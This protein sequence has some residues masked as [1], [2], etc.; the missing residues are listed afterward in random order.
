MSNQTVKKIVILGGG[1]AGW[2]TAAA[3]SKFLGVQYCEIVLVESDEIGTVGVGEAT[4]PPMSIFNKSLGIDENDFLKNTQGTFKLGIEFVNW[5]KIGSRYIHAFGD[6][7]KDMNSMHFYQYWLKMHLAGEAAHFQEYGL[8]AKACNQKKFMRSENRGNSP[9]SNIAY[10]F[11]FDASLYAKYLRNYAEQKGIMR[12]EGKVQ[13]VNLRAEDG[14]IESLVLNNGEVIDG[15]LFIDC[16]G[17]KALLIG[18]ALKVGYEDWTHWLP[19]DRAWAVQ[20]EGTPDLLPYTR[21]TAHEAGWQWRIPLQHR[22]GNGHVFASQYMSEEKA[23]DILLKNLD[24]KPLTEPRLIKFTTGKRKE[25]WHKNCVSVGLASGFLEPLESTSIH[26]VQSAIARI[27][28]LFPSNNFNQADINEFNRQS[29]FEYEKIRDFII[30]HY[31]ANERDDSEFWRYC[32]NMSVPEA[33]SRRIELFKSS[34]RV[35]RQTVEMFSELSWVE[36][37]LGQGITPQSYDRLVDRMPEDEIAQRLESVRQVI[38]RS[39]DYM[40]THADFIAHNCKAEK[41]M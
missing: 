4:V 15:D 39:V 23:R 28:A 2:M 41:M 36:V 19:C 38:S 1:T 33:L 10:A 20:C 37:L 22:L 16:S 25:I 12:I 34:G 14:F 26:L 5:G 7:G 11:H 13:H 8:N 40:P 31:Y 21:S 24:G 29:D 35:F 9:L 30:L 18:D 17:F 27:L 3:L 32:R 6:V